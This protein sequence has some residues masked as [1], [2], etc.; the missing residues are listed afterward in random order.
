MSFRTAFAVRNLLFPITQNESP[1]RIRRHSEQ[2]QESAPNSL[3]FR[4]QRT[5][6]HCESFARSRNL[7]S[8]WPQ[9]ISFSN[10]MSFRTA[11]AARNLLL[12]YA[13]ATLLL[14]PD[15]IPNS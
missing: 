6:E 1:S 8:L 4:A 9:R 10:P 3:S 12:R 13:T 5:D 15:V 14:Q 7:L 11:L 2:S